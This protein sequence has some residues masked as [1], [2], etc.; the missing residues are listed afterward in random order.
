MTSSF[1]CI[2]RQARISRF[3]NAQCLF[4]TMMSLKTQDLYIV[5]C[6]F[7]LQKIFCEHDFTPFPPSSHDVILFSVVLLA[8]WNYNACVRFVE[9]K[10]FVLPINQGIVIL[11][12]H[13]VNMLSQ[14]FVVTD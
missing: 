14:L 2:K 6:C 4:D 12:D 5:D 13:I 8:E 9:L 1:T 7:A 11:S 3:L 10:L